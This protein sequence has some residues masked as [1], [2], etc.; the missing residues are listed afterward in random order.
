MNSIQLYSA[1]GLISD[2]LISE[3]EESEKKVNIINRITATGAIAACFILIT[4]F[5]IRSLH[6]GKN[7]IVSYSISETISVTATNETTTQAASK[8][9]G[10]AITNETETSLMTVVE[11]SVE[12][13]T[14]QTTKE[15]TAEIETATQVTSEKGNTATAVTQSDTVYT[16]TETQQTGIPELAFIPRWDSMTVADQFN[17][18][19]YNGTVYYTGSKK[20]FGDNEV[21]ELL[22]MSE[23]TGY[24]IY[25]DKDYTIKCGV[26][27]I[28]GISPE[29][30][31]AVKY[32]G[33]DEYYPAQNQYY[34]PETLGDLINDLNLRENL[35]FGSIYYSFWKDGII[36]NGNYIMMVYTLPDPAVIWDLL[37]SD[38]SL[39]NEGDEHY[40]ASDMSISIDIDKLG[41]KNISLAVN[42]DGYLQTN[43]LATGKSFYIGKDKIEAFID[44]V[45]TYGDGALY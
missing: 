28:K 45:L 38:T 23:S 26:Y 8:S 44:Y 27:S 40:T 42:D 34:Y 13:Q 31:V 33:Y 29:C 36:A 14:S 41:V 9:E 4:V 20:I 12:A 6:N 11:P 19:S 43:I 2:D 30:A 1:I 37:L 5:G 22:S 21:G 35:S 17:N 32:E 18:F 39:K 7:D 24:D 25:E 15:T 16:Q 10:I 3:A